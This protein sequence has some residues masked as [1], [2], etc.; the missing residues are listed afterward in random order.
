MENRTV[1]KN[2]NKIPLLK[3]ITGSEL[4]KLE[5]LPRPENQPPL[6]LDE[7]IRTDPRIGELLHNFKPNRRSP[8]RHMVY[9]DM[10]S[11]MSKLVVWSAETY[12][13]RTSQAYDAVMDVVIDRLNLA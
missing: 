4:M 12:E 9:L 13:L 5:S 6:S 8:K 7:I 10:K 11:K 3:T 1:S 2:T